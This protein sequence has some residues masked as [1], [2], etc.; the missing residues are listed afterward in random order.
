[1][2][3]FVIYRTQRTK[4]IFVG[5]LENTKVIVYFFIGYLENPKINYDF[6]SLFIEHKGLSIFLLV[7]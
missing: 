1:M 6:L 2:I 5:Y 4:Y 7:I 3:S